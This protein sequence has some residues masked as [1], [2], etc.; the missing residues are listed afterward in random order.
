LEGRQ[1]GKQRLT[2]RETETKKQASIDS[3]AGKQSV[4]GRQAKTNKQ[5]SKDQ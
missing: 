5:A 4:K 1:A 2:G 3:H